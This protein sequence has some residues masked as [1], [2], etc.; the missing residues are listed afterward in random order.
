MGFMDKVKSAA[1]DVAQQTKQATNKAQEKMGEVQTK[2]KMNEL[3][4]KLGWL[5]YQ[6]RAHA[7]PAGA[8]ADQI[9]AEI[10]SLYAE[11]EAAPAA[12]SVEQAPPPAAGPP[13]AEPPGGDSV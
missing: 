9:V 5:I 8:E 10:T 3:A 7:K 1:S 4:T 12:E 2:K 6:E 11:L 13:P